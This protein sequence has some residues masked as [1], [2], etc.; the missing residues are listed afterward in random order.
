MT[1]RAPAVRPGPLPAQ[2]RL[3]RQI[4]AGRKARQQRALL[5]VFAGAVGARPGHVGRRLGVTSYVT[6]HLDRLNAGTS[7]TPSS[8]PLNIL[9]AGVD[10]GPG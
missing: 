3:I 9:V 10:S 5:T 1:T 2:Q 7:G 4:A 6:D 8:G